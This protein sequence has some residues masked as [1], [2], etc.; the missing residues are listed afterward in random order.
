[1]HPANPL[2]LRALWACLSPAQRAGAL[3]AA[4]VPLALAAG[5]WLSATQLT[6]MLV[7][8]LP[9]GDT[10]S[11]VPVFAAPVV[12]AGVIWTGRSI[13]RTGERIRED[14]TLTAL[15][16]E[17]PVLAQRLAAWRDREIREQARR[18]SQRLASVLGAPPAPPR[19]RRRL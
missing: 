19:R 8:L 10:A 16:L 2:P 4:L 15:T 9:G 5:G 6:L 13:F 18:Q 14:L 3:A 17:K 7:R 1:M 12:L 11:L